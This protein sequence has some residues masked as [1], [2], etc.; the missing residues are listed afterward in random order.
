L[1]AV[2]PALRQN[3]RALIVQRPCRASDGSPRLRIGATFEVPGYSAEAL[4]YDPA[5]GNLVGLE[6]MGDTADSCYGE[7]SKDCAS[8]P[9]DS[10][11]LDCAGQDAGV[12]G[13]A[14][15]VACEEVPGVEVADGGLAVDAG[16]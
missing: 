6:W 14:A 15:S 11:I 5:T 4:I 9:A 16:L 10:Y 3:P 8:T 12:F 2:L 7:I 13:D 1:A